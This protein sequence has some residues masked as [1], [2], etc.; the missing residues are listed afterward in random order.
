MPTDPVC[1]MSLKPENAAAKV[2]Y[3]GRAYYFCSQECHHRFAANPQRYVSAWGEGPR[4]HDD[5][6]SHERRE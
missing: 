6:V 5:A 1:Q 3:I 4:E 2:E